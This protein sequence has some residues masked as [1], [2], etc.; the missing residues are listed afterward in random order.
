MAN[1]PLKSITFPGLSDTYTLTEVD[2]ALTQSG[3][4]ADAKATGDAIK[5][6]KTDLEDETGVKNIDFISGYWTNNTDGG[7]A[8]LTSPYA[9]FVC[10]I[11][12]CQEGDIITINLY[13]ASAARTYAYLDSEYRVLAKGGKN[14]TYNDQII[15]SPPA[16]TAY[17]TF[18]NRT[19]NGM[20]SGYYARIGKYPTKAIQEIT[21]NLSQKT[22]VYKKL[23]SN[24]DDV[25]EIIVPGL[26]DITNDG[27]ETWKPI[28]W[29]LDSGGNLVVFGN[30]ESTSTIRK[31]QVIFTKKKL[32][33]RIGL[34]GENWN[35][36]I[37]LTEQTVSL[38]DCTKISKGKND[39]ISSLSERI[40]KIE[41][42]TASM[43][44]QA[45]MRRI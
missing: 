9:D 4:G 10:A 11:A 37:P 33:F 21:D 27:T 28:N 13:G 6:V 24:A 39:I 22:V 43:L 23:L 16:G 41:Q 12:P 7:V 15:D 18:N 5:N 32:I 20:P 1:I 34:G 25:N 30:G 40:I 14:V 31:T 36:W 44:F 3:K 19:T 17:V 2:A 26:Y 29:P 38:E 42:K 8:T 35:T 45:T